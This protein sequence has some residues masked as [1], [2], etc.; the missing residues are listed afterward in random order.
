MPAGLTATD[1]ERF[2]PQVQAG[3]VQI[4]P[5]APQILATGSD[6]YV[7]VRQPD[8]VIAAQRLVAERAAT[9]R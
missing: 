5:Q 1:I 7:Q 2:W 8:L 9:D 6:H 4:A 3:V